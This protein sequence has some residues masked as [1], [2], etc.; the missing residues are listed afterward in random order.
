MKRILFLL[1]TLSGG[2]A[3]K[4]IVT[5][6]RHMDRA[7]FEP[8]LAV[9]DM[10][11]SVYRAELP[12]EVEIVD[13][14]ATRV[15][16]AIPKL[17]AL[18]RR[19]RPDV[20]LSTL[21]HL[22]LALA[23]VRPFLPRGVRYVARETTV[24]S[25]NLR[26]FSHPRLWQWLYRFLIGRI[27]S[28]ICQSRSMRDDLVARLG[29]SESRA[30]VISNPVDVDRIVQRA[31]EPLQRVTWPLVSGGIRLLAVGRLVELKG[32]D[33]LIKA[34]AM[35]RNRPLT[36]VI[37]GEGPLHKALFELAS[38]LGVSDRVVFAGFQTNPYPFYKH[39]DAFVL[40]SR[41]EGLPNVVLESLACGTPVIAV[42]APGGTREILDVVPECI[43]AESVSAPALAA[44]I[45]RWCASPRRRIPGER[46]EPYEVQRIVRQYEMVLDCSS[47]RTKETRC[48]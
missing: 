36:L 32:F 26:A 46:L 14:G 29:L 20:V 24:V 21:G 23:L 34:V 35:L 40:S 7:K 19:T 44:A 27:D 48:G 31:N 41:Y 9:V 15:R 16:Y 4:V 28:V 1:P 37:L 11:Q 12:A 8:M 5:L 47:S 3:E 42:P 33:L 2:G 43:I 22:N 10:R 30:T 38:S 39:A 6:I 25:E 45:E 13:L 17:V 18:V